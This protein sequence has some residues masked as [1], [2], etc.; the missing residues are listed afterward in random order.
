[1]RG[2]NSATVAAVGHPSLPGG[3]R[4]ASTSGMAVAAA[5]A[6]ATAAITAAATAV[7]TKTE[8]VVAAVAGGRTAPPH[9]GEP[10]SRTATMPPPTA[11]TCMM[12]PSRGP[13]SVSTTTAMTARPPAASRPALFSR[14][15][16]Q[17]PA[18]IEPNAVGSD[19]S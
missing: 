12:G 18:A 4:R 15:T 8:A 2:G 10:S 13:A 14:E 6:K 7:A 3:S 5:T 16:G 17:P 1:M 11:A 9:L 19:G